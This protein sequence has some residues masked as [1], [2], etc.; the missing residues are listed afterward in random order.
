MNEAAGRN[1]ARAGWFTP[2]M[3]RRRR[4]FNCQ[5]A[6]VSTQSM[7]VGRAGAKLG[8]PGRQCSVWPRCERQRR[9]SK[10]IWHFGEAFGVRPCIRPFAAAAVAAGRDVSNA[11]PFA[12]Q[13]PRP[14]P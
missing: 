9:R 1:P 6:T 14:R 4:I 2:S 12:G 5:A 3:A 11:R 8:R 13:V 7:V 10:S